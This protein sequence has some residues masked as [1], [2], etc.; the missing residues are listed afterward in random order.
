MISHG[1]VIWRPAPSP[2]RIGAD[3]DRWCINY[4]W[5]GAAGQ[6]SRQARIG[7]SS[8]SN[9]ERNRLAPKLLYVHVR[10]SIILIPLLLQQCVRYEI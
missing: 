6:S 4:E 5:R 3:R 7:I 8:A 2:A 10:F 9:P 1:H